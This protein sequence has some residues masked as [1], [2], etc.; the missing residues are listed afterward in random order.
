MC[1]QC[2]AKQTIGRKFK[3][4]QVWEP[5]KKCTTCGIHKDVLTEFGLQSKK[6]RDGTPY[7]CRNSKCR[8]CGVEYS[9]NRH[10]TDIEYRA[11]ALITGTKQRAVK[12]GIQHNLT[13]EW[14]SERLE[15]GVCEVT[16][17]PF[18][19]VSSKIKGGHR[20]FTPSLD[21]TDP[22][23]GYTMDNTKVVCW[24]YNGAKGVGTHED[25]MRMVEALSN[26]K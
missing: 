23:K 8:Q 17:L 21:R 14:L 10:A 11:R 6:R 20:S 4:P 3:N 16:G 5:T 26:V 1:K 25:V 7:K 19:F 24:I 12:K 18:T 2:D 13:V 15:R 22:S 9:S